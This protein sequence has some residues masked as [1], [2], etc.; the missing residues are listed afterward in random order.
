MKARLMLAL[1]AGTAVFVSASIAP[2]PVEAYTPNWS[3]SVTWSG[4][5]GRFAGGCAAGTGSGSYSNLDC[6]FSVNGGYGD[7]QKSSGTG[8]I[9]CGT[10]NV[11]SNC[12]ESPQNNYWNASGD[13]DGV[14]PS[15]GAESGNEVCDGEGG[16]L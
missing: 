4:T 16:P 11:G 14:S 5:L 7:C 10:S 12:N 6:D 9:S 8:Y 1:F 2:D 13:A 3:L 15:F